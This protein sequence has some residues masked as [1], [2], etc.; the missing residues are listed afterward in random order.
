MS[1][2]QVVIDKLRE[3]GRAASRVADGMRGV[4]CAAALPGG[5]A[6]MPGAACVGKLAALR[7]AWTWRE[8]SIRTRLR[9]HASSLSMAVDAYTAHEDQAARDLGAAPPAGMRGPV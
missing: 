1:G 6:G 3:T 4:D 2:Y 7:Q 9:S 8:D 5:D